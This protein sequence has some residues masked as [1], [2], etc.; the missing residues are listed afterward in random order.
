MKV[1]HIGVSKLIHDGCLLE[2]LDLFRFQ[3]TSGEGL[4]CNLLCATLG[5]PD[6]FIH[7]AKL[8]RPKMC[9]Q[10]YM[11]RKDMQVI[12]LLPSCPISNTILNAA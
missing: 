10:S 2:K 12:K 9:C 4:Y 5:A 3:R 1:Y 11:C 8:T 7:G 6:S